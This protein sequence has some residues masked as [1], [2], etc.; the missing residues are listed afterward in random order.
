MRASTLFAVL[1]V[2][3]AAHSVEEIAFRL[4]EDFPP[5][6]F[7]AG[8]IAADLRAGFVIANALIVAF[9]VACYLGPVRL[10][11]RSARTVMWGWA[12]VETVNGIG[13]PLRSL[14]LWRYTAGSVSAVGLFVVALLLARSLGRD[15]ES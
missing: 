1:V 15:W 11:W 12:I 6:A 8:I 10:R 5:A 7:V 4:Y 13:H 9:G 3:Q 14:A 2:A